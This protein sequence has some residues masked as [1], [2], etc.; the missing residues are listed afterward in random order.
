VQGGARGRLAPLAGR[1]WALL[2]NPLVLVCLLAGCARAEQ[3]PAG[4]LRWRQTE[5]SV[6]VVGAPYGWPSD[7]EVTN[8][9]EHSVNVWRKACGGCPLPAF[10]FTSEG[11]RLAAEADGRNV[12]RVET[13]RWCANK[14]E[15]ALRPCG[16]EEILA[17]TEIYER[18]VSQ[19]PGIR[20]ADMRINGHD[21][22]LTGN[23]A[24]RA[25]DALVLHEMG[26]F[27]G[28]EHTNTNDEV[29]YPV[30]I[31]I[32]RRLRLTPTPAEGALLKRLYS[33]RL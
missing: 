25:L 16:P 18:D 29:M 24:T 2:G 19:T 23:D 1:G 30:P 22:R 6:S 14:E 5:V 20:E 31:E 33:G 32:G 27:L 26:H 15:S 7:R 8:S 11:G 28:L 13:G 21:P 17:R 9:L 4:V 3:A 10:R 12:V